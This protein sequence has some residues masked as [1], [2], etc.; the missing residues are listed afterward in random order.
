MVT[1]Q[2]HVLVLQLVVGTTLCERLLYLTE[3]GLDH[4][5]RVVDQ[6]LVETRPIQADG[7]S[8]GDLRAHLTWGRTA[9][10]IFRVGVFDVSCISHVGTSHCC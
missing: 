7:R 5:E 8:S 9:S 10:R 1:L 6:C 3:R 2:L 4:L